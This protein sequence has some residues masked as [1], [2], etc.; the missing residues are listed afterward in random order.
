MTTSRRTSRGHGITDARTRYR[1][2]A[3]RLRKADLEY[4]LILSD[5]DETRIFLEFRNTFKY[6]NFK[7]Y[8]SSE[9]ERLHPN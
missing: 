3:R 9:A 4:M 2:A 8:P 6:K 7:K 1:T 5:L